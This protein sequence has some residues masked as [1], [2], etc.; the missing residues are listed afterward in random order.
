MILQPDQRINVCVRALIFEHGQLL[1]TEWQDKACSFLIGG[2]VNFGEQL[3]DALHREVQEEVG[4]TI[5]EFR[6]VYFAETVFRTS[7]GRATHEYGWYFLVKLDRQICQFGEM[8]PNPDDPALVIHHAP[9]NKIGLANLFPH[10]LTHY[11]PT[12]YASQFSNTPR[13][14]YQQVSQTGEI[15]LRETEKLF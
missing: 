11:L 15:T 3:V 10:F 5:T 14:I 2:R 6:L 1:L 13:S 7:A 8:V 12:D 4:A 9:I